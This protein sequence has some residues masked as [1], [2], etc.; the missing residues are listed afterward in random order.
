[1][2]CAVLHTP[3]L[4]RE[5]MEGLEV[6]PGGKYVD[7]TV[8]AGGHA[9]A[10]LDRSSPGGTLLGIDQDPAAI[11]ISKA[12]LQRYGA[13]VT[14][15]RE[16]FRRLA[17]IAS[18]REFVP[19]DGVLLDLGLSSFQ[20]QRAERGFSFQEEGPL[21]MRMDPERRV[22]AERLVNTLTEQ[23]LTEIIAKYGEEAKARAIARAIVR[24]RPV[25]TTVELADLVAR[26]VG[27]RGR[28]HPATKTFQ[29]LRM[30]VNEELDA[31]SSVLPQTVEVLSRGGRLAVISFHSLEDRLVK[32]FMASEA[33]D[34]IC[35]PGMPVCTCGHRRTLQTLTRKPI[36]PSP[37]E[38]NRNPRSRS[39]K[40]RIAMK[41]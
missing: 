32:R 5:V 27:R 39:A 4:L 11:E 33:S 1:M 29:A 7:C 10:I 35:P 17:A 13:R 26:T 31:L 6:K 3:V 22:T 20:L 19:A 14:L 16:S 18:E 2:K 41:V 37:A 9:Q 21:D 36:R 40:L 8:G 38:T 30:A 23:E 24:H 15:I 28:L 12:T 25:R 34:C